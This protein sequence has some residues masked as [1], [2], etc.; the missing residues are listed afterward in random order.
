M[1]N[2]KS[3]QK[4]EEKQ[5]EAGH[6]FGVQGDRHLHGQKEAEHVAGA[7]A[8]ESIGERHWGKGEY[9]EESKSQ[10]P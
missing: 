1:E 2:V 3:A 8:D 9:K 10:K 4:S 7:D 6:D 5:K